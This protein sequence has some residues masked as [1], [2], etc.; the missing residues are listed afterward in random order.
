MDSE[1]IMAEIQPFGKHIF[2][3][4]NV[5]VGKSTILR[6]LIEACPEKKLGGFFTKWINKNN[7]KTGGLY[8]FPATRENITVVDRIAAKKQPDPEDANLIAYGKENMI[9]GFRPDNYK[10]KITFPE[11]FENIGTSYL[12]N[13]EENDIILMDEIGVFEDKAIAFKKSILNILDGDT[14]VIGVV[15][16]KDGILTNAVKTHPNVKVIDVTIKSRNEIL[17]QLLEQLK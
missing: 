2:L 4:G 5:Q 13:A 14:Q 15:R 3:T 6:K 8:I 12:E 17:K 9:A 16:D 7:I 1:G 11:V 10:K